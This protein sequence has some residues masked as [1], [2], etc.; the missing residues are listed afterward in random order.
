MNALYH[1]RVLESHK[2]AVKSY[3]SSVLCCQKEILKSEHRPYRLMFH[4]RVTASQPGRIP[5]RMYVL[6]HI[7]KFNSVRRLVQ[8]LRRC[9]PT[10]AQKQAMQHEG[11]PEKSTPVRWGAGST[12]FHSPLPTPWS[13]CSGEICMLRC[14]VAVGTPDRGWQYVMQH[15]SVRPRLDTAQFSLHSS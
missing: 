1:E 2:K 13:P 9:A 12:G 11:L 14:A 10:D 6:W 8:Q 15:R 7:V 3:Q 5:Y 4:R